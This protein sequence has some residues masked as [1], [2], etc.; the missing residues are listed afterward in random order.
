M[1]GGDIAGRPFWD[2]W[3]VSR[4]LTYEAGYKPPAFDL[5]GK[6]FGIVPLTSP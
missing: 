3:W 5:G 2:T 1:S 4:G 6:Y